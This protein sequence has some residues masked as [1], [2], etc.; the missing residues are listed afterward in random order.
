MQWFRLRRGR[1]RRGFACI[2]VI[3]PVR[4]NGIYGLLAVDILLRFEE[5]LGAVLKPVG[6]AIR[7]RLE[8]FTLTS[9]RRLKECLHFLLFGGCSRPIS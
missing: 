4:G 5:R 7:F 1:L 2:D 8:F 6:Y 3:C 9:G